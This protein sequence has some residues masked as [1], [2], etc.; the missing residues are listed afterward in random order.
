MATALRKSPG[1]QRLPRPNKQASVYFWLPAA[2]MSSVKESE[3]SERTVVVSGLPVGCFS[4]QSLATLVK[5]Y[6]QDMKNEGGDV[7]DVIYPTRTKGVAYVTFKEKKVAENVIRKKKH[8]LKKKTIQVP[9]TVSP[10]SEKVFCSVNAILDLSVFRRQVVLESLIRDLTKKIPTLCFSPLKPNGRISVQGSFLAIKRLRELLLLKA[11]F[12]LERNRNFVSEGKK[13][14]RQSL[15]GS[16]QRS[17]NSLE[18]SRTL[19]PE[20]T[21]SGETFVLDT[22]VFLYLKQKC[23]C[24]ESTLKKF[25][26]LSQ[27]RVDGDITTVCLRSAQSGSQPSDVKHAK[28]LVE[29]YSHSLQF[30]LRK[31]TFV[32]EGKENKEKRTIKLACEQV[33]SSYLQ[34]LVNFYR[35]H[36]DI[37]GSSSDT[38]LFKKQVMKLIG[39][40]VS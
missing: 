31:E 3:A 14:S 5:I 8:H 30:K 10:F 26:V 24:Y 12:L 40:K 16:L 22:D 21:R 39:R 23:R 28:Q 38:Y 33:S 34:V 35:T 6:F 13:W 9:L 15:Q 27:E 18:S 1:G 37:I 4:D 2:S 20:M 7:E 25:N 17:N 32:L 29:K 19:V 36:I 11:S